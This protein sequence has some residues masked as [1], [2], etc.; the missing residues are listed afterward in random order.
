MFD[1]CLDGTAQFQDYFSSGFK[2]EYC[3]WETFQANCT[4]GHVIFMTHA[5]YGRMKF[6]RCIR[7][8]YGDDGKLFDIGCASDIMK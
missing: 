2:H 3:N 6:G 5:Q 8:G 1:P 4:H 7:R